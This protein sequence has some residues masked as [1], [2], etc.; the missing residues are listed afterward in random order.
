MAAVRRFSLI[1]SGA[2]A[3]VLLTGM[4]RALAEVGAPANLVDT[5]FGRALIVKLT[6]VCALVGLGALNHFVLVPGLKADGAGLRPFRRTVSGE[7]VL[8]VAILAATGV[9][10][11]LAPARY[12]AATAR[13]QAASRRVLVGS[14]YAATVRLRLTVSP[15]TVGRNDFVA[16]VT[17]YWSGK[18]LAGVRSVELDFSLPSQ[19]SVQPSTLALVAGPHGVWQTSGFELSVAGAWSI[20][21]VLQE[22]ASAV[23]VPLRLTVRAPPG[24]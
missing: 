14:D 10:G 19:P 16:S 9:L 15:G 7:I 11:G 20:Q 13:A 4:S 2:L 12:A 17:D 24:G 22:A 6:F 21:V 3:I 18:P 23:T 1:A 5:S 8:G